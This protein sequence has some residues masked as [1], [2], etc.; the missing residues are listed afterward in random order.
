VFFERGVPRML[1]FFLVVCVRDRL[2][3]RNM[4]TTVKHMQHIMTHKINPKRPQMKLGRLAAELLR[5]FCADGGGAGGGEHGWQAVLYADAAAHG[6]LKGASWGPVFAH[7]LTVRK[8]G[9]REGG[10]ERRETA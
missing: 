6:H 8:G 1:C 9:R 2:F 5:H 10:R 3:N 7:D 4:Q